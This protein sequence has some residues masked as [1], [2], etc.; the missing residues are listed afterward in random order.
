MRSPVKNGMKEKM[1]S[2]HFCI[3]RKILCALV[4]LILPWRL[5]AQT[6]DE[7]A[8]ELETLYRQGAGT[9]ISFVVDGEKNTLSFANG[10]TKFRLESPDDLIISDGATIW[11]YGKK[12]K[13]VVIDK[14]SS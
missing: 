13:E 7:M 14:A 3:N 12:K 8:K 9:T 11:H 5:F 4:L 1:N 6:A 2:T 10:S